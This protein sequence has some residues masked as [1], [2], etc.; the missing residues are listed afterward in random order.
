MQLDN[1]IEPCTIPLQRGARGV[2]TTTSKIYFVKI[3]PKI[4]THVNHAPI[5]N[6]LLQ[7]PTFPSREGQ[8]VCSPQRV[9]STSLK[10]SPNS[11]TRKSHPNYKYPSSISN[12]PLQRGA[13]GVFTTTSKIYFV[14]IIPKIPTHENYTPITNILRQFPTSPSQQG[15]TVV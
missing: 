14:K 13:R 2:F 4:L 12:F 10:S 9:K 15:I 1:F 6:I 5:V 8:V 3:I 7:F 11:Q